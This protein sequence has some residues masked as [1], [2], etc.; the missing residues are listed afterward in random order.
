MGFRVHV[1]ILAEE[2]RVGAVESPARGERLLAQRSGAP[3]Q[4]PLLHSSQVVRL[5]YGT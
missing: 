2:F 5:F 1:A 3:T 4:T